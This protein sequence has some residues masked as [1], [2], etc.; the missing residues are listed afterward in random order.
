[1]GNSLGFV[2]YEL[3]KDTLY[4]DGRAPPWAPKLAAAESRKS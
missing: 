2:L 3:A 1:M 4:V